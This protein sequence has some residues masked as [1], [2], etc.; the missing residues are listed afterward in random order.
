VWYEQDDGDIWPRIR[1]NDPTLAGLILS[2]Y[3]RCDAREWG[4]AIAHNTHLR[5]LRVIALCTRFELSRFFR[6]LG[7]N[8]SI[9]YLRLDLECLEPELFSEYKVFQILA[10]F[11]QN[12]INLRCIETPNSEVV[13][14][15]QSLTAYLLKNKLNRFERIDFSGTG[16]G[17]DSV[18][19]FINAL[20]ATSGL[21]NLLELGLDSNRI[22][23]KG[24]T[25]LDNLFSNPECNLRALDLGS[26]LDDESLLDILAYALLKNDRISKLDVG[27]SHR[28]TPNGWCRFF[29]AYIAHPK[30]SLQEINL[31][32]NNIGQEG[33]RCLSAALV[34]NKHSSLKRIFLSYLN[35]RH[36]NPTSLGW[37]EL[38]IAV[39]HLENLGLRGSC[40]DD[41]AAV[42]FVSATVN[43][44]SM[45]F[46]G[47]AE[48]RNIQASGWISCFQLMIHSKFTYEKLS[49]SENNIDDNGA[50][51]L[52]ESLKGNT[53]LKV[54]DMMRNESITSAGW[55]ACF[56][57]LL[58][59]G[60]T[61]EKLILNDNNIDDE[62][63]FLLV[64][65]MAKSNSVL[66]VNLQNNSLISIN[67]WRG[68][69]EVLHPTS[70]SQLK[71]LMIGNTN[72]ITNEMIDDLLMTVA[73]SLKNNTNLE[74]LWL[75]DYDKVSITCW[76]ELLKA[77]CDN[78]SIT[79][80]YSSNHTL[81]TMEDDYCRQF[82]E[83]DE[84]LLPC[85]VRSLLRLNSNK[86]KYDV[87]R[88][89]IMKYYFLDRTNVGLGFSDIESTIMPYAIEWI[90]RDCLGYSTMFDL[91]R[92]MPWLVETKAN[93]VLVMDPP[94]KHRRLE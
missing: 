11:I 3:N 56:Q 68:F 20:N 44:P 36:S 70:S 47:M 9:E 24:C 54:L 60:S 84:S 31:T 4:H 28:I 12:N 92:S 25:A 48:N 21:S 61:L 14:S 72:Q 13:K 79:N 59:S 40:I 67:G 78:S 64:K 80:I 57:L 37:I 35:Y 39:R 43:S 27:H 94:S 33:L 32:S 53:S 76:S 51:L 55:I 5:K 19:D 62:G 22:A 73:L 74:Y 46:L 18:A 8:R 90:G 49:I 63:A 42:A 66:S 81:W 77:L 83:E 91:L 30:C 17:D 1:R 10:P 15:M 85:N 82:V 7:N 71:E 50:A 86:N 16:M 88:A 89:K 34:A 38:S 2:V 87:I 75:C 93:R 29:S 23:L 65:F 69:I 45:K 6:G 52:F 41:E 58:D 26:S